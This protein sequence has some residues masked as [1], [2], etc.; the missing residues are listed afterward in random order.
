MG[1]MDDIISLSKRKG[2]VF[3]SSEI[4]SGLNGCWDFG[5]LGVELLNN[6]SNYCNLYEKHQNKLQTKYYFHLYIKYP[7][8]KRN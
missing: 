5:P 6:E 7:L 1:L 2:F 8:Y 3:Q 4:Y